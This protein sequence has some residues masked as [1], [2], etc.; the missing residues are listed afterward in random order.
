M[1]N[2]EESHKIKKTKKFKKGLAI[3]NE[4][5]YTPNQVD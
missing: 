4:L 2:Q 3:E 1:D 5:C